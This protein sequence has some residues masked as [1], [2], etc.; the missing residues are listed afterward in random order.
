MEPKVKYLI[1]FILVFVVG[2]TP[3]RLHAQTCG[4]AGSPSLISPST[5]NVEI[6]VLYAYFTSGGTSG[7]DEIPSFADDVAQHQED[8]YDEMSYNAHNVNVTVFDPLSGDAFETDYSRGYYYGSATYI[9]IEYLNTEILDKAWAEDNNVF[10]NIDAVFIFYGGNVFNGGSAVALLSHNSSH[11]SGCGALI[12]WGSWGSD[13]EKV[14]KWHMA[15]EY[16]HLLSTNGTSARQLKDQY[17]NQPSGIYNIMHYQHFNETQ[18]MPAFI[19]MYLGWIQSS[20]IKE[21]DPT[22]GGDQSQSV[23]LKDTRLDPGSGYNVA[24][25]KIPGG[26]TNEH[27]IVENRQGTGS[28]AYLSS[29]GKG[30]VIWHLN[31]SSGTYNTLGSMDVEIATAIDVHGED[32]LDDGVGT[33][34]NRG[35][36]TDFFNATNKTQFTPWSNPS[37][38]TGYR[39]SFSHTVSDLAITNIASGGGGDMEFDFVEEFDSGDITENSV[40]SGT[41]EIS[42]DITVESGVTLTIEPGTT[43]EFAT[44]SQLII[45]GILEADGTSSDE[46]TFDRSGASGT[47]DG[48]RFQSGSSGTLDYC[49]ILNAVNGVRFTSADG[50]ISNCE[51][52]DNT[53]YAIMCYYS[54]PLI[55]PENDIHDNGDGIFALGAEPWIFENDIYDNSGDGITLINNSP[56]DIRGYPTGGGENDIH[57]NGG[58]GIYAEYQCNASV[59]SNDIEDNASYEVRAKY[60][61][62]VQAQYNYWGMYPP[63][64]GEFLAT[65][66]ATIYYTPGLSSPVTALRAADSRSKAVRQDFFDERLKEALEL[67]LE[68]KY[69]EALNIYQS[70]IQK[71]TADEATSHYVLGEIYRCYS[72]V[73]KDGFIDY[74]NL[75]VRNLIS[76]NSTLFRFALE[77][78]SKELISRGQFQQ[79]S[80]KLQQVRDKTADNLEI[81]KYSLFNLGYV[82][83]V[84]LK[85]AAQAGT[86]FDELISEYPSDNLVEHVKLLLGEDRSAAKEKSQAHDPIAAKE[87]DDPSHGKAGLPQH[88][89]LLGNYP[90]PFNPSTTIAY[91]LPTQS[92][93][94]LVIFDI[95]GRRVR[96]Y[97]IPSQTQG[98]QSIQ[99]D[100]VRD[101]GS[102]AASGVYFYRI[103]ARSLHS[104][105]MFIETAKLT[106]LK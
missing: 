102:V 87:I 97:Q 73:K 40:W 17:T 15:H 4:G 104:N 96:A 103:T 11:Y 12:E 10:N 43:V 58:Y 32:W 92:W 85:D 36:T 91:S 83:L 98:Y 105:E 82:H 28:D 54:D 16:G 66:G 106:L 33:G 95:S 45:N 59:N 90:N 9:G 3:I 22:S 31:K 39:Y 93:V 7:T 48:I 75:S 79:A 57:D 71:G 23:T 52:S 100:G 26:G 68:G 63:S 70:V 64:S 88:Y 53:G 38:E 84:L 25:I 60:S 42:D 8:Y 72:K 51:I 81:H 34:E 27:F 46:I 49:T 99:W 24:R 80:E 94:E 69:E 1:K 61:N 44:G 30:L 77:L 74:L 89:A 76:E 37:T 56:A 18:P 50:Q 65:D 101:N 86:Y 55:G 67:Q 29:G 19:L 21:I 13:E 41:V 6:L 2:L 47:W 78:E 5:T 14:H 62:T 35:Y 20:W